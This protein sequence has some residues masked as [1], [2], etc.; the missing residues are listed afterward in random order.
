MGADRSL[1]AVPGT[2]I[3]GL[4]PS[5]ATDVF[6]SIA[7]IGLHCRRQLRLYSQFWRSDCRLFDQC[8]A[9]ERLYAAEC[10]YWHWWGHRR[11]ATFAELLRQWRSRRRMRKSDSYR[12]VGS[13]ECAS[14]SLACCGDGR[15]DRTRCAIVI[16]HARILP[17]SLSSGESCATRRTAMLWTIVVIV[18]VPWL[19]RLVTPSIVGGFIHVCGY[20]HRGGA[21]QRHSKQA[22]LSVVGGQEPSDSRQSGLASRR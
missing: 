10:W 1:A 20:C 16:A 19:L 8:F 22:C 3:A 15:G 2:E 13:D 6:G 7:S 17:G 4:K 21:D 5:L 14:G 12:L 11:P 18:I 9:I